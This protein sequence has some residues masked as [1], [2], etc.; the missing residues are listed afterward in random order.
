MRQDGQEG[1]RTTGNLVVASISPTKREPHRIDA[2]V[3]V[4]LPAIRQVLKHRAHT[5]PHVARD[6]MFEAASRKPVQGEI[7]TLASTDSAGIDRADTTTGPAIHRPGARLV[8]P[9][10]GR[11]TG[12]SHVK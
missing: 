10:D 2:R 6:H 4:G 3:G 9:L 11:R 1:E 5:Q 12:H 7:L 8:P